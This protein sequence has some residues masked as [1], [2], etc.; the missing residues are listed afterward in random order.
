M[1]FPLVSVVTAGALVAGACTLKTTSDPTET[2]GRSGQ[3]PGSSTGGVEPTGGRPTSGEPEDDGEPRTSGGAAGSTSWADAGAGGALDGPDPSGSGGES[4]GTGGSAGEGG[5]AG[6]GSEPPG[7]STDGESLETKIQLSLGFYHSCGTSGD[8]APWCWGRNNRGQLGNDSTS[9]KL[10]PTRLSALPRAAI[11]SA[12]PDHTC[13]VTEAGRAVCWGLNEYGQLGDGSKTSKRVPTEVSGFASGAKHIAAGDNHSCAVTLDG[14]V[15]CWGDNSAGQLGNNSTVNSLTPIEVDGLVETEVEAVAAGRSHTCALTRAGEVLCWGLNSVGQLG[16]NSTDDSPV[17]VRVAGLAGVIAIT[18]GRGKASSATADH[19]CALKE[20][21][22][23]VCWGY[24]GDGRLGNDSSTDSPFP[25]EVSGLDSGVM[26]VS[27]GTGHVCA[28]RDDQTVWCWGANSQS[29]LG[30]GT[31]ERS[32]V[33]VQ[34]EIDSVVALGA[35]AA[36]TCAIKSD[37][38]VWCWG[39]N[40]YGQLGNNKDGTSTEEGSRSRVPVGNGPFGE[41]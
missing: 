16:D 35:G 2:G 33:P 7:G 39:Y 10:T 5:A 26:A 19:A 11:L 34:A 13:A 21:G 4:D 41:E 15:L 36:H 3:D 17:P 29:Q 31:L 25:V 37:D 22:G 32:F 9:A 6:G 24:N 8:G 1:K 14:K 27:A 23:V 18:A 28:L 12:G 30:D 20:T 40:K 38:S